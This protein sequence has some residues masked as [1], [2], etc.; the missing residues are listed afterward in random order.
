M[1]GTFNRDFSKKL[2][3]VR[4]IETVRKNYLPWN[5]LMYGTFN[6]DWIFFATV[7]LIEQYV[8]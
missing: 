3:S 5:F 8:F 2:K 4:L 1:Y 6:R 7:R